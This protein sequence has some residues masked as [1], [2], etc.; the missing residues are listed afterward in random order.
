LVLLGAALECW[1]EVA[2]DPYEA[3]QLEVGPPWI[4][5]SYALVFVA[6]VLVV[7]FKNSGRTHLD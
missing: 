7:G 1:A 2:V 5:I 3:P 4:V 6:A